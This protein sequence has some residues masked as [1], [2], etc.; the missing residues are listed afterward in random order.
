MMQSTCLSGRGRS[1]RG[2]RHQQI[3]PGAVHG[4]HW[5]SGLD[6]WLVCG[7]CVFGAAAGVFEKRAGGRAGLAHRSG[8]ASG[9]H[10]CWGT[11]YRVLDRR[12]ARFG[13]AMARCERKIAPVALPTLSLWAGLAGGQQCLAPH[14]GA[15]GGVR[16]TPRKSRHRNN[17]G[18]KT[19]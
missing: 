5:W 13:A 16:G 2:V 9:I 3:V 18:R 8:R 10:D 14:H 7:G 4:H 15:R 17:Q 11:D 19:R 12:T 1:G 6:L